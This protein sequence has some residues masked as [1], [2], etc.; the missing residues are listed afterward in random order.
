MDV[1]EITSGCLWLPEAFVPEDAGC[2]GWGFIGWSLD[3]PVTP[4]LVAPTVR[5]AHACTKALYNG[6]TL[7]AVYANGIKY[8]KIN[9]TSELNDGD[10]LVL[11]LED[12]YKDRP[13]WE[14]GA[15]YAVGYD[16][17]NDN[18]WPSEAIDLQGDT[19]INHMVTSN[20]EWTY[21]E[22]DKTL[23]NGVHP[24]ARDENQDKYA[25]SMRKESD[26]IF[27]FGYS[28]KVT[29]ITPEVPAQPA[30]W[31]WMTPK[32]DGWFRREDKA[33]SSYSPYIKNYWEYKVFR[34]RSSGKYTRVTSQSAISSGDT[35]V[36]VLI[37]PWANEPSYALGDQ[38]IGYD[39]DY[40]SSG[41]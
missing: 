10:I 37:D 41:L 24:L 34:K 20:Y 25:F 1:E 13:G 12:P 5:P 39:V 21:R 6:E 4:T 16:G 29:K 31:H 40:S 15:D 18:I 32:E 27:W 8:E 26:G 35:V 17:T 19:L 9:S 14:L 2:T 38:A 33:N 36:V 11:V 7:Y 22:Y 23:W 28:H 3:Q 30:S